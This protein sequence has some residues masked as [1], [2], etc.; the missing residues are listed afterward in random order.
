LHV[1]AF[2]KKGTDVAFWIATFFREVFS[3][4]PILRMGIAISVILAILDTEI[5]VGLS[6]ETLVHADEYGAFR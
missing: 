5:Y 3:D 4:E 1:D 6:P 2:R